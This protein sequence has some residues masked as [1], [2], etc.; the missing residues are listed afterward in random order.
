[1]SDFQGTGIIVYDPPRGDMRARTDW[2]CVANVDREITRYYRW[3][4]QYERHIHLQP[5]AWDAHISVVRGERPAA[6]YH[7]YW[8]KHTKRKVVFEYNHGDI[9][10]EIDKK[11]GGKF[12]W[13]NVRCPELDDIRGELG[14]RTGFSY[15]V[16]VGRTYEYDARRP[17]R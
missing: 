3:W 8:K 9:R 11:N 16:T 5:P 4:L 1:M 17:K 2:W 7:S 12:Y 15:H 6:E 10:E 14:L 13:V